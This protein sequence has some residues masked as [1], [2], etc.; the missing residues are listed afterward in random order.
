MRAGSRSGFAVLGLIVAL[1]PPPGGAP[2]VPGPTSP[3]ELTAQAWILLDVDSGV[4]IAEFNADEV[5][6]MASVTKVMTALMVMEN[7]ELDDVV[8]ITPTA[9]AIS[10][11][12]IG[13][14]TGEVWT[15][16][17]LLNAL[18]IRSGNDAAVALAEHIGGSIEGFADLMNAKALAL[19][20]ENSSFRN[21]H[22]LDDDQHF[23][24]A[25]ELTVIAQAALEYPSLR[26]IMATRLISFRP[27]PSGI[28]RD[29]ENTNKLLGVYPGVT[30]MKTGFTNKAGRV[31]ISLHERNGRTLIGVVMGSEDHFADSRSL[32]DWG[33]HLITSQDQLNLA[34]VPQQGGGGVT[35]RLGPRAELRARTTTPLSD[36][37]SA[38][39]DF[40]SSDL[41]TRI[42]SWLRQVMPASVGGEA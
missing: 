9:A 30:G 3:P 7:A 5:R 40:E 39:S 31:L 10:E 16:D 15:V 35:V 13:L 2:L 24:T 11:S 6:P 29:A 37:Q 28:A 38:V 34:R 42:D 27:D 18:L 21:P 20:L 17:A 36:G 32:L 19:G 14:V 8:R 23:T 41:A 12:E 33:H 22:G 25:R 1:L 4:V 26:T